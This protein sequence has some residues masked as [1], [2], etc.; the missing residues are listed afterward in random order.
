MK[1]SVVLEIKAVVLLS[2]LSHFPDRRLTDGGYIAHQPAAGGHHLGRV[3]TKP[4]L[5]LS[6]QTTA[7][8]PSTLPP[9]LIF[10]F[11]S[12]NPLQLQWT[13]RPHLLVFFCSERFLLFLVCVDESI[14]CGVFFFNFFKFYY[15]WE[16]W[17]FVFILKMIE[18]KIKIWLCEKMTCQ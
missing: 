3:E 14:C 9:L 2:S 15:I 13:S 1:W 16:L 11:S 18:T 10:A 6:H 7:S 17:N 8:T 5:F 4:F 12:S